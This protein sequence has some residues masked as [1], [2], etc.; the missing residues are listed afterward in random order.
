MITN[1]GIKESFVIIEISVLH[2]KLVGI[3]SHI[4]ANR[5]CFASP[6]KFCPTDRKMPPSSFRIVWWSSIGFTIPAFH[7]QNAKAIA[8]CFSWPE[9]VRF[10]QWRRRL[11]GI[12]KRQLDTKRWKVVLKV[13]RRFELCYTFIFGFMLGAHRTQTTLKNV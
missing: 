2:D 13:S 10:A 11:K 8:N 12:R 1:D 9:F 5:Y 7:R 6:Q 3:R 4:R